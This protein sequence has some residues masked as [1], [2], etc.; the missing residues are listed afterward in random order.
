[1]NIQK[2]INF[3]QSGLALAIALTFATTGHAEVKSLPFRTSAQTEVAPP[4]EIVDG[5]WIV[6]G[7]SEKTGGRVVRDGDN[8]HN[9]QPVYRFSAN[10]D[11]D[12]NRIIF[13]W[14]DV[15]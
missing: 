5:Q 4:E 11:P 8:L 12:P 3:L 7:N 1:M 6:I 2:T 15:V 9:R 10:C 14:F 13:Y